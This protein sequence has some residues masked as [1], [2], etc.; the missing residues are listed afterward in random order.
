MMIKRVFS[1][2][3]AL[4]LSFLLTVSVFAGSEGDEEA[5]GPWCEAIFT[6]TTRGPVCDVHLQL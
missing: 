4:L 2:C 5:M 6:G 3:V 1:V